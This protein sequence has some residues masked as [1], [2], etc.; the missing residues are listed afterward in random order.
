MV[1]DRL[2][3]FAGYQYLRDYDSQP[4]TDPKFPRTYEQNKVFAK[5]TWRLAPGWQLVQSVHDEHWVNPERPDVGE[6][7]RRDAATAR[8]G[9]GDDLR[10]SDAHVVGQYACGMCA[11]GGSSTPRK[12]LAEHRQLGR[13][14]AGSTA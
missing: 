1:R 4:G 6:A 2:W 13:R 7:V 8:V 5:L 14:Q 11:S 10:P 9:A 12:T 3:F